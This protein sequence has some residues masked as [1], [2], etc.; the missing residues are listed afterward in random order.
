MVVQDHVSLQE[1]FFSLKQQDGEILQEFS[2][3]LMCLME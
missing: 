3:A 1:D 2:N